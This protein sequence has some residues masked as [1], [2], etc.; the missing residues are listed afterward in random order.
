MGCSTNP[1]SKDNKFVDAAPKVSN[2]AVTRN[3]DIEF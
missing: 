3:E 1:Y 2:S